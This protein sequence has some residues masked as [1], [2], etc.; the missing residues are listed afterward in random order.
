[1]NR[2]REMLTEK[3]VSGS[4]CAQA[5]MHYHVHL[6]RCVREHTWPWYMPHRE[7]QVG[8]ALCNASTRA[9]HLLSSCNI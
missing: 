1:M 2:L 7:G 4:I 9:R 5:D 6:H 8:E 3:A